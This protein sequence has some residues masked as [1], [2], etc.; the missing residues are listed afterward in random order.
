VASRGFL[1]AVSFHGFNEPLVLVGGLASEEFR[2]EIACAID[3]ATGP[4]IVVRVATPDD[5]FN[6]DSPGNI[7]NRLTK[8]G[9]NGVQIEQSLDARKDRWAEI[10]DAVAGV[11][12][13]HLR[14]GPSSWADRVRSLL[15]RTRRLLRRFTRSA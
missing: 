10:A 15:A 11:Y 9:A 6:G 5:L 8:G 1:H 13:T 3:K 7:V 2:K 14:R 4:D 12:E